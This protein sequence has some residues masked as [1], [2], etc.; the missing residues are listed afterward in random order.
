M[1]TS[2]GSSSTSS[3]VDLLNVESLCL[4]VEI[5]GKSYVA[6]DNVSFSVKP[7]RARGL[8]GESGSGKSLTL[9]AIMGLLPSAVTVTSGSIRFKGQELLAD[10]GKRLASV[11]GAGI[12]MVFQEPMVAL[13]PVMKVGQQIYDSVA[14]RRGL[15]RK[16]A[17]LFAV[18][19][20]EQVGIQDPSRRIDSY[21][22][23][24]SGGMRQRVM[25]AAAVA[26]GPELI[27]CDEPTT[28]LDVTVQ[29][30]ILRL[31]TKLQKE[32]NAGLLYV[33]HDLGVVAMV[34]DSLS[35]MYSGRIVEQADDIR[36]IFGDARHPYTRALLAAVPRI[37]GPIERLKGLDHSAPSLTARSQVT[38]PPLEWVEEG[39]Q[40]APPESTAV[41]GLDDL[42]RG[43]A[44]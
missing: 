4:S 34:C 11:R 33:T 39:W 25:I 36:K 24:L 19:L 31:F 40:V 37:D 32:L 6:I 18:D 28:A 3:A 26:C 16:D 42:D 21:P 9:R 20:M 44:P 38:A 22:F 35:V 8:V 29:A 13:N 23:E 17:R 30:Q 27:L 15:S 5:A 14:E 7:G 10:G 12:S 41:L 2:A 43:E 1:N